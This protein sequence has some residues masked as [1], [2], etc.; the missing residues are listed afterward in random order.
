M[1]I[2][3]YVCL[4]TIIALLAL[5]AGILTDIKNEVRGHPSD[6]DFIP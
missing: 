2:L 6:P 4:A 5:I 3:H 1:P